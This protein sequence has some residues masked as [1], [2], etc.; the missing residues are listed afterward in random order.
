M[1]ADFFKKK[2]KLKKKNL[3]ALNTIRV[4]EFR[5]SSDLTKNVGPVFCHLLLIFA[6][7][8]GPDQGP[9]LFASPDLSPS[10]L[11]RSAADDKVGCWQAESLTDFLISL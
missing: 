3:S 10:C 11:Q 4:S 8:L 5:S 6:N 9:K 2:K 1:I 7:S